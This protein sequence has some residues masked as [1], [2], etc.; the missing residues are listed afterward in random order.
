[1]KLA[2]NQRLFQWLNPEQFLNDGNHDWNQGWIT[3]ILERFAACSRDEWQC[4]FGTC[5][6]RSLR[7]DGKADCPDDLSDERECRKSS[8]QVITI[9]LEISYYFIPK[10]FQNIT[11]IHYESAT[12]MLLRTYYNTTK[13]LLKYY[14]NTSKYY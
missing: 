12:K 9:L 8:M 7:C 3:M 4:D 13:I 5:I 2:I 6:S 1:M 10:I 11:V 14:Q